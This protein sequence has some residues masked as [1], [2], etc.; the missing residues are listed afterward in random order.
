[1]HFAAGFNSEE[2]KS[3]WQSP[4]PAASTLIQAILIASMQNTLYGGERCA[5]AY[6]FGLSK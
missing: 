4:L 6:N 5:V 2:A 1:M 3:A